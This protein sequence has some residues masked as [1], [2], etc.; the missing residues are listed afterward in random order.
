MDYFIR[1]AP[2]K[3][4]S[5][6]QLKD[7][8]L[9]SQLDEK[10]SNSEAA[11]K[12]PSQKRSRKASKAARKL[13]EAET[14]GSTEEESCVIVENPHDKR[15]SAVEADRSCGVLSSDATALL[16]QLNPEACIKG[17][18]SER[19]A[20]KTVSEKDC[21]HEEGSKYGNNVKLK[22]E[23]N[24][25]ELSPIVPSN[26]KAKQVKTVAR[27]PRKKQQQEA[28]HSDP[29][30]E[31][32]ESSLCDVSM[33]VNVDEASQLNSSTVTISFEDFVR[34][35]SQD[36]GEEDIE[37]E[38]GTE[39]E[40]KITSEAEE[41]DTDQ[42]DIPKVEGNVGSGEP[43]LQVSPRT[44]TIQAEV[45]VVS[46]KQEAASVGKLASIFNR[47]KGAMSP[48][49][50]VLSPHIEAGHQLPSISL[51]GKR[52]SN[53]VL[54]EEDLELAVL[55]SEST[56]KCSEVE[57][58]QFMAAFKQASLDGSKTKPG[59]SQGKQK[60]PG[61]KVLDDA[62]KVAEEETI[63][64]P[65][66]EQVPT[67]SQDNKVAKKKP[68]GKGRKKAKE[69]KEDVT[70]PPA[71]APVEEMVTTTVEVDDKREEPPITSTPSIPAVRRSRREAVVRQTPKATPTAPI[72]KTRQHNESED[73]AAAL[74]SP[75]KIRKSKHGVFIAEMVCPP[76]AKQSPI[77]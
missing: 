28:K 74:P 39:D 70:T 14:V 63:I 35:Q 16:V 37:D 22:P 46:P 7:N 47:R 71:A 77:R 60:Q 56:P 21:H 68:A 4:S 50:A 54:H 8:C 12:Q 15:E 66:V 17:G 44:V 25:I 53:V 72:R 23:L 42:L 48:A 24:S 59:K 6:E 73:T 38:Q 76:D 65:S 5:P 18:G 62:D 43:T 69:E 11:V 67:A 61:E 45:H 75:A 2:T 57:R 33:E 9:K 52:K 55:E 31:E 41:M 27:N 30:G 58:K 34:S 19:N 3:T 49:E 40:S 64:P 26:N 32:I 1:K 29:E 13:V 51:T 10:C 20:T 36:R